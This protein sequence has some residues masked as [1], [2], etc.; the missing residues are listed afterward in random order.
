M[1]KTLFI[2]LL[3]NVVVLQL[4]VLPKR[5][6]NLCLETFLSFMKWPPTSCTFSFLLNAN[7]GLLTN[8]LQ[9]SGLIC[10]M[11]Q[12]YV[13]MLQL[14]ICLEAF[15]CMLLLAVCFFAVNFFIILQKYF[16]FDYVNFICLCNCLHYI[17]LSKSFCFI[18]AKFL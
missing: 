10:R 5:F 15:C 13:S 4:L 12:F 1:L 16:S 11:C 6:C 18:T 7:V 14:L 2:W 8:A 17:F 3:L 9:N